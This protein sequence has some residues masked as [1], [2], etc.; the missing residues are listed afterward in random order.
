MSKA[1][2]VVSTSPPPGVSLR[3]DSILF[4]RAPCSEAV[5]IRPTNWVIMACFGRA[6]EELSA[7]A[8]PTLLTNWTWSTSSPIRLLWPAPAQCR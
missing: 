1:F 6:Q 4:L 5:T 3:R 8:Q 7:R 2:P